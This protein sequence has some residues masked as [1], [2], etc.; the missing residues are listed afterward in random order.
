MK[1]SDKT[2][3]N[4]PGSNIGRNTNRPDFKKSGM[5][6]KTISLHDFT[7]DPKRENQVLWG[8]EEGFKA[9]VNK[10]A[11]ELTEFMNKGKK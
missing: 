6:I 3:A 11:K 9:A 8:N 4:L 2:R 1:N 5:M 10:G 7:P